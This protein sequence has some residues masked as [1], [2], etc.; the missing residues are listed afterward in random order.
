MASCRCGAKVPVLSMEIFNRSDN[1]QVVEPDL[2]LVRTKPA[3]RR[4]FAFV[5]L[6]S[7]QLAL[8]RFAGA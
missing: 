6:A 5:T 2:L 3:S 8:R 7:I 1:I 4:D